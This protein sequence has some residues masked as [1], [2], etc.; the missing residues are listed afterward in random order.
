VT[1][2]HVD[3]NDQFAPQDARQ[4]GN[5][6]KR[7]PHE[8][9]GDDVRTRCAR[10]ALHTRPLPGFVTDTRPKPGARIVTCGNGRVVHETIVTTDDDERV[11]GA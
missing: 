11:H 10:F 8:R 6:G 1:A 2:P 4:N 9:A 5:D 3:P 7:H